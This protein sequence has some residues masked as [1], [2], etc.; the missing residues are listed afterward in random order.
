MTSPADMPPPPPERGD[1]V[2]SRIAAGLAIAAAVLLFTAFAITGLRHW[3]HRAV[4]AECAIGAAVA[5]AVAGVVVLAGKGR[6][7]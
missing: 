6:Q 3:D 4:A 1:P 2:K 5:C 7:S